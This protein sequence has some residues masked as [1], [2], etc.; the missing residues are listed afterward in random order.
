MVLTESKLAEPWSVWRWA[1]HGAA[2][3]TA[4]ALS[5]PVWALHW[6]WGRHPVTALP[7]A[8]ELAVSPDRA[9]T[10]ARVAPIAQYWDRNTLLLDLTRLSG[11]GSATLTPIG[12][13]GWPVR[14]EFRVRPGG[15]AHLEV[16]GTQR[17][18]FAV[19]AQGAAVVLKLDPGVYQADTARINLRWSATGDLPH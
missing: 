1:A 10:S 3:L 13:N 11:A 15:M 8:S 9:T 17:V 4:L 14:L 7:S 16:V 5:L 18:V 12:A 19:P 2:L 6:P